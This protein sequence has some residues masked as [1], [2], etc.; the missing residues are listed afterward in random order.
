MIDSGAKAGRY[1]DPCNHMLQ[2]E[3]DSAIAACAARRDNRLSEG[4]QK[5]AGLFADTKATKNPTQ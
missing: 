4:Q 5:N 1:P 3:R 2:E